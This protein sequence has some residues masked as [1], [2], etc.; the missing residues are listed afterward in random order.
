MNQ[1]NFA[2]GHL[3]WID[4]PVLEGLDKSCIILI[5]LLVVVVI[6]KGRECVGRRILQD[7]INPIDQSRSQFLFLDHLLDRQGLVEGIPDRLER[8]LVEEKRELGCVDS[9][10]SSV[11]G[12]G[13]GG[14]GC[15]AQ[16][17]PCPHQS[18]WRRR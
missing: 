4:V 12:G 1:D 7:M 18:R 8:S 5:I 15:T 2:V 3:E 14:G 9:S 17:G 6:E 16:Q 13:Q 10:Y 11:E